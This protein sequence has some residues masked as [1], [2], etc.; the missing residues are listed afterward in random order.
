ALGGSDTYAGFVQDV[1][2]PIMVIKTIVFGS[3]DKAKNLVAVARAALANCPG[4]TDENNG[5]YT[6]S[7]L[8][9]AEIGDE[10][11]ALRATEL[12][13]KSQNDIAFVRKASKVVVVVINWQL[14][15][16]DPKLLDTVL[17]TATNKR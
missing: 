10:T 5:P 6:T 14:E 1:G 11:F 2:G 13:P 7:E 4:W 15:Q 8:Q 16:P 9:I 12:Q 17:L 3:A